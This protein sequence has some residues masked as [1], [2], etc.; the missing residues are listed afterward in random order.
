MSDPLSALYLAAQLASP[1]DMTIPMQRPQTFIIAG[2]PDGDERP[3][4]TATK[5]DVEIIFKR[6]DI[7]ES[8]ILRLQR[9]RGLK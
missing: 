4:L 5:G 1:P 3:E 2:R 6:L 7:L 9:E 8:M